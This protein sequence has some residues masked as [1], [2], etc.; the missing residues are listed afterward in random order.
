MKSHSGLRICV[1]R[2]TL[3]GFKRLNA[4]G[5]QCYH[6][7][8]NTSIQWRAKNVFHKDQSYFHCLQNCKISFVI[9]I[10]VRFANKPSGPGLSHYPLWSPQYI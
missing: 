3:T 1:S 2:A 6:S 5:S 7:A 4:S 8:L 9:T 10:F